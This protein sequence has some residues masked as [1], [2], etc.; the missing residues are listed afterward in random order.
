M[1]TRCDLTDQFS[2]PFQS[3]FEKKLGNKFQLVL[4]SIFLLAGAACEKKEERILPK[5][6]SAAR[7]EAAT[8]L[9][10]ERDEFLRQAQ[11]EFDELDIK[12]ADLRKKAASATGSARDKL[13]QQLLVLEE[14]HKNV[15]EKLANLQAAIGEKWQELKSDFTIAI[16]RFRKSVKNAI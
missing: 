14:E 5:V 7:S 3:G 1:A 8:K 9:K 6:D 4:L 11:K 2:I 12:L 13:N 16:D 10:A 15:A